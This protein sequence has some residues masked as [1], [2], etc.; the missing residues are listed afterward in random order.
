MYLLVCFS[1]K[2]WN[3]HFKSSDRFG[4]NLTVPLTKP[5]ITISIELYCENIHIPIS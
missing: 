3:I 2:V 5:T 1:A 4:L